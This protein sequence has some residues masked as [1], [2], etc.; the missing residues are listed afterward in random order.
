MRGPEV[1]LQTRKKRREAYGIL[2]AL[3]VL[4]GIALLAATP[5]LAGASGSMTISTVGP[6]GF[7]L[8]TAA[9]EQRVKTGAP[10]PAITVTAIEGRGA[11]I[12]P[13]KAYYN[14]D[15]PGH[16]ST[17]ITW[18][19]ARAVVSIVDGDDNTLVEGRD[20][21]LGLGG[22]TASLS[23]LDAYL[24]GRLRDLGDEVR[25]TINFDLY[26][27]AIFTIAAVSGEATL[28]YT[29]TISSSV[30]GLVTEPGEGVFT[31]QAGTV[32]NL[33]AGADQEYRFFRW[34]GD[35]ETVADVAAAST[36]ITMHDSYRITANFGEEI[37]FRRPVNRPFIVGVVAGVVGAGLAIFLM[38]RRRAGRNGGS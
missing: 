29:L 33:L 31:Y 15:R 3:V 10:A 37:G 27:P 12:D 35:V 28:Q 8:Y 1:G 9:G 30:G 16:A 14:L 6:L 23:V 7:R 22:A 17:T 5:A 19:D 36:K 21:G 18:N 24:G 38:R 32:V 34:M 11:V 25:L 2:A 26:A 4:Q 20:Y 13:Q